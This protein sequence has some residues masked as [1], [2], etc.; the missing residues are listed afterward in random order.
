MEMRGQLNRRIKQNYKCLANKKSQWHLMGF[1]DNNSNKCL[2]RKYFYFIK[3]LYIFSFLMY[4]MFICANCDLLFKIINIIDSLYHSKHY[5]SFQVDIFL[6]R[7][8]SPKLT[9]LANLPFFVCEPLTLHD[10]WQ[11]SG[12]GQHSGSELDCQSGVCW[13]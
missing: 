4:L 6:L 13:T 2:K 3:S 10:H 12:V 5:Y 1:E 7:K 8:I 11:T 9:S